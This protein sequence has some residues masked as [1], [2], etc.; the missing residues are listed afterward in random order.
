MLNF[1]SQIGGFLSVQLTNYCIILHIN[2]LKMSWGKRW[3]WHFRDPKF[4]NF[5]R[6]H[7]PRPP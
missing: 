4:R 6:E 5:L 2:L 1:E 7:A 3:K